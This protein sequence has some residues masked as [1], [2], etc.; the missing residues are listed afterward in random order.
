MLN[1]IYKSLPYYSNIGKDVPILKNAYLVI[2]TMHAVTLLDIPCIA[3]IM[4]AKMRER[5]RAG[6][7]LAKA[8]MR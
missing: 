3:C 8:R 5:K 6:M 4:K 7:E 2:I 1:T